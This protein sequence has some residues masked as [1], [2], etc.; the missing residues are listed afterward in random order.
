MIW[1][2]FVALSL[3]SL[4]L[5]GL[6]PSPSDG[7]VLVLPATS[8][9]T[10]PEAAT[11]KEGRK[12]VVDPALYGLWSHEK[13]SSGDANDPV[14]FYYF[15]EGGIGLYRTGRVAYNTTHSYTWATVATPPKTTEGRQPTH[16]DILLL[17]YNKSGAHEGIAVKRIEE[18][19]R[20]VLLVFQ[21]PQHPEERVSRYEW[22][23]PPV[24]ATVAPD[25][26]GESV[27]GIET[28]GADGALDHRLWID[29]QRH[30]TGG[31][32]FAI[33]QW[34]RAA[35]DGRGVGWHHTGD[36][37]D[38]STE[39]L[40]FRFL[41][42]EGKIS[43]VEMTF[44]RTGEREVSPVRL[45][46]AKADDGDKRRLRVVRDPRAFW[47]THDYADA[48]PSFGSFGEL[49]LGQIARH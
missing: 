17:R 4:G 3:L 33:Y 11:G 24:E 10:P 46:P 2:G 5:Y 27:D 18:G 36:F 15:H 34:N 45:L 40:A 12:P 8:T 7:G 19:K 1:R 20:K 47:T 43:R 28:H 29:L 38:W 48:G 14:S 42:D 25:L 16:T 9:S 49:V 35:I 21:D 31:Q 32:T 39:A 26:F 23:A 44:V 30:A 41:R 13:P 22:H 37:D 6:S